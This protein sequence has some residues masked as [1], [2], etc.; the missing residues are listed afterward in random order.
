MKNEDSLY[1]F[2]SADVRFVSS[3]NQSKSAV[4]AWQV[5]SKNLDQITHQSLII[6]A[7]ITK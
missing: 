2:Q 6:K 7:K 3:A 1:S 5:V 4:K